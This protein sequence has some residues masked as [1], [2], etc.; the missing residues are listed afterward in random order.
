MGHCSFGNGI[1]P[2]EVVEC[3]PVGRC[4]RFKL[5]REKLDIKGNV[6]A[7]DKE[8]SSVCD[9]VS[10]DLLVSGDADE[11]S[12]FRGEAKRLIVELATISIDGTEGSYW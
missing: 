4:S 12:L 3:L 1:G 6:V 7:G 9:D 8:R 2:G 5:E 11:Y 10:Q